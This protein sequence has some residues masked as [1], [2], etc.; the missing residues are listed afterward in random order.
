VLGHLDGWG[1]GLEGAANLFHL[2]SRGNTSAARATWVV[3]G[4]GRI[5]VRAGSCRAG[6][7]EHAIDV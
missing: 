6:F 7:I 1:R 5:V 3:R 4:K 2:R